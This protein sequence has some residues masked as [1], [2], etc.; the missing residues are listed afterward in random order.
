MPQLVSFYFTNKAIFGFLIINS[1]LNSIQYYNIKQTEISLWLEPWFLS[2]S[3]RYIGI[4]S[5]VETSILWHLNNKD[6]L[7][8]AKFIDVLNKLMAEWKV[9]LLLVFPLTILFRYL[10]PYSYFN[11]NLILSLLPAGVS[12]MILACI[13]GY[14]SVDSVY[15]W[16][17]I[18]LSLVFI[19]LPIIFTSAVYLGIDLSDLITGNYLDLLCLLFNP[20][21][22]FQYTWD[23]LLL[24]E[25]ASSPSGEGLPGSSNNSN[26]GGGNNGPNNGGQGGES[27]LAHPDA[28]GRPRARGNA[29]V[30]ELFFMHRD[31][32]A[33]SQE[34]AI[35]AQITADR[36]QFAANRAHMKAEFDVRMLAFAQEQL[37]AI[38]PAELASNLTSSAPITS[39]GA[40]S[41]TSSAPITSTGAPL[42]TSSAP[43]ASNAH[44]MFR[45]ANNVVAHVFPGSP[46]THPNDILSLLR[47]SRT[48][49]MSYSIF[50]SPQQALFALEV[51][52]HEN[53]EL[54]RRLTSSARFNN[55]IPRTATW[56]RISNSY[57]LKD[58]FRPKG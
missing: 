35:R 38:P 44:W 20:F 5:K 28:D 34:E 3:A 4:L 10:Q 32:A 1:S 15:T 26:G 41:A 53:P 54:Y 16:V 7:N 21:C 58:C 27:A 56:S 12:L 50:R 51:V 36:A 24:A 25:P 43:L 22:I 30:Q 40:P 42:A 29:Y 2:S 52:R 46:D 48:S 57:G 47:S 17:I 18:R 13:I 45:S 8:S 11:T 14:L 19:S 37:N 23:G 33:A 9:I 49:T 39:T 55:R 6:R 31:L